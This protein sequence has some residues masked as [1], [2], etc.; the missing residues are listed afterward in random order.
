MYPRM[1][2]RASRHSLRRGNP[3]LR[4][5]K[6]NIFLTTTTTHAFMSLAGKNKNWLKNI[7]QG[8]LPPSPPLLSG[9]FRLLS[10][11]RPSLTL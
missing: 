1:A 6:K 9:P 11:E 3:V 4:G 8:R 2:G 10:E 5:D 7:T